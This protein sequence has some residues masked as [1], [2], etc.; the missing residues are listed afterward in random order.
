V[1]VE[2][3]PVWKEGSAVQSAPPS[4]PPS[5]FVRRSTRTSLPGALS[6]SQHARRDGWNELRWYSSSLFWAISPLTRP[7]APQGSLHSASAASVQDLKYESSK[8]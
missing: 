1:K 3:K 4:R 5:E 8:R 2:R 6:L 7:L